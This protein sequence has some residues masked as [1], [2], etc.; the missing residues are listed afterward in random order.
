[1]VEF[2]QS[3]VFWT[4][5]ISCQ[6]DESSMSMKPRY[7]KYGFMNYYFPKRPLLKKVSYLGSQSP[8]DSVLSYFRGL[9]HCITYLFE[10]SLHEKPSLQVLR[11]CRSWKYR[12][13][14]FE[15]C[16]VMTDSLHFHSNGDVEIG[17]KQLVISTFG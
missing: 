16:H 14:N 10:S 8:E 6:R 9:N 5:E 12:C 3:T 4:L 11:L 13:V 2:D 1:M 15:H 17:I 7:I